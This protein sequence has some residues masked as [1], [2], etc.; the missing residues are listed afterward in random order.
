MWS[1]FLAAHKVKR[2]VTTVL[3]SLMASTLVPARRAILALVPALVF[4]A[5]VVSAQTVVQQFYIPLPEQQVR[6]TLQLLYASTGAQF[7][8]VVSVVVNADGTQ[9]TYDHWEDGY[10][11]D[12]DNPVQ[13]ST[14]VWGDGNDANGIAPGFVN[15]PVG[16]PGG[17]VL[18]L[19]N[20]VSLP[21]NP[22]AV[23]YDGRDRLGATKAVVVSRAA[24]ATSPGSVLAGAVEV[25]STLDY[26]T[27]FIVPVGQN[28]SAA[29]MFEVVALYVQAAENGT[30][31]Q[32]D[33]DGN[34][35]YEIAA[36]LARGEVYH[37]PT[38]ILSGARVL[39][40]KPV[41]A[42]SPAI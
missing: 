19:R 30:A 15:D 3:F 22:S 40:S 5:P 28:V 20:L 18:S 38:G 6:T 11:V 8:S 12:I 17:S 41:Q 39:S 7:D 29:S 24:W 35:T 32:I 4:I 16:L 36:T 42:S 13:T 14:R 31:V 34:G 9:I 37:V 10:E 2:R 25:A 21:R 27:E 23:L 26:G 33:A 1:A